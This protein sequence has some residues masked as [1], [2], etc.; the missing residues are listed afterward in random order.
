METVNF[1]YVLRQN[2][3]RYSEIQ[4]KISGI[5]KK[6]LTQTLSR[7]ESENIIKSTVYPVVSPKTEYNLTAF[8]IEL[9]EPLEVMADWS[10]AASS[11]ITANL[12]EKKQRGSTTK[13]I[14]F[15]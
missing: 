13:I 4:Y 5:S 10:I 9:I 2:T 3:K 15:S 1:I 12:L 14:N 7:L 11:S 8:R 6:M